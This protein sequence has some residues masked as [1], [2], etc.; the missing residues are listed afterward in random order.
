MPLQY[1]KKVL[2][3]NIFSKGN[4]TLTIKGMLNEKPLVILS[5]DEITLEQSVIELAD[6]TQVPGGRNNFGEFNLVVQL[7]MDD[8]R[9]EM[10]RWYEQ[11]LNKRGGAANSNEGIDPNYKRTGSIIYRR[12]FTG[13][14]SSE[15]VEA[16]AGSNLENFTLDLIG[17]WPKS[18]AFPEFSMSDGDEG[19]SDSMLTMSLCYD[20]IR[21]KY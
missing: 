4:Q 5:R 17:I 9:R 20:D 18:M 14:P 6:K 2:E 1:N 7:A 12:Q 16:G 10:F 8:H 19:D 15:F 3:G 11:C 13:A 21:P